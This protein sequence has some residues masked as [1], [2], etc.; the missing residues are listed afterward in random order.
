VLR[1][2]LVSGD[3]LPDIIATTFSLSISKSRI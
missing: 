1:H 2:V 3:M